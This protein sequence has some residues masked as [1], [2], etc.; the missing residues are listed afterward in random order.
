MARIR[1]FLMY[2]AIQYLLVFITMDIFVSISHAQD[3]FDKTVDQIKA[4]ETKLEQNRKRVEQETAEFRKNHKDNAP[5]D[6]FESDAMY[7]ERMAKLEVT[8]SEHRLKLLKESIEADQIEHARLH[9]EH[10]PSDDVTVT[11]DR[12][13]ANDEFFLVTIGT[14]TGRFTER[15]GI[16]RDDARILYENWD[17]VST[18]GY[19]I[20][21]PAPTYKRILAKVTLAY[22]EIW[23]KPLALYFNDAD[24]MV[25]IPAGDFEMGSN[26]SEA[27][28]NEKPVHTV[29]LD[30]FY[31]DK[32]EVTVGQYK[33]FIRETGHRAPN[34]DVVYQYSPT[35]Q[36]PIIKVSWRD[37]MAY[38]RWVG[39]RLPTEAEW[40]K[41]ARG[42]L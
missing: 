26:D 30:A 36:H 13:N 34:W 17:R 32:Y 35:D 39:K 23:R 37:A 1:N 10:I 7:K 6:M 18:Q 8:V 40:E 42:G 31:I 11:L 22:P 9:R 2:K 5:Q 27:R 12:Y 25:L 21:G 20:V 28:D 14:L 29:Y 19:L 4:L 3:A 24:T 16:K 33:Q 15:L 38:A 41:A